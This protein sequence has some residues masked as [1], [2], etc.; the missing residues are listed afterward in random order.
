VSLFGPRGEATD[1]APQ[2]ED[3]LLKRPAPA[4]S[5]FAGAEI[6]DKGA[7]LRWRTEYG[8]VGLVHSVPFAHHSAR[9][10]VSAL[11]EKHG[12]D[13]PRFYASIVFR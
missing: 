11:S 12:R 2:D 7:I 1:P 10:F 5:E 3:F 8:T 9:R 13:L 4:W 6:I